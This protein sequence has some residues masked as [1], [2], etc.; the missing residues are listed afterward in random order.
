MHDAPVGRNLPGRGDEGR[1]F[2][3]PESFFSTT[4]GR[5]SNHFFVTSTFSVTV[6]ALCSFTGMSKVPIVLI[7]SA[8]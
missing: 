5:L 7:G 1:A 4:S 2:T 6:T 3:R 8:S